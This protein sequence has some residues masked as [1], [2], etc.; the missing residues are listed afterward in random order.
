MTRVNVIEQPNKTIYD[1]EQNSK[2]KAFFKEYIETLKSTFVQD[3]L[4]GRE[5]Y[6]Y[7]TCGQAHDWRNPDWK[8]FGILWRISEKHDYDFYIV[9]DMLQEHLGRKLNC[10]CEVLTDPKE[11]KRRRL[12]KTGVDFDSGV[13]EMEIL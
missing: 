13:K 7:Y 6:V 12:E 4:I 10:E 11:L 9:R 5:D 1:L 3:R 2:F 8:P